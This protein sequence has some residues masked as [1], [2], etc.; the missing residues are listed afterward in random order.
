MKQIED[1]QF[2]PKKSNKM[3]EKS[4]KP[5]P[6]CL[7]HHNSQGICKL[8]GWD[9]TKKEHYEQQNMENWKIT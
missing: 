4:Q 2:K 3:K 6:F 8:G 7:T 1:P 9:K 5:N